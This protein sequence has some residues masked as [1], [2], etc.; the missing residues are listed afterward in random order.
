MSLWD[1]IFKFKPSPP[2]VNVSA[3]RQGLVVKML[4]GAHTKKPYYAYI[5]Y[6]DAKAEKGSLKM[7]L[8]IPN[9]E[10]KYEIKNGTS[11][12]DYHTH[13]MEIVGPRDSGNEHLLYYQKFD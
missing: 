5:E 10:H 9:I 7:I 1:R 8:S 11:E 13:R 6:Y 3:L 4:P 12:W 2:Q